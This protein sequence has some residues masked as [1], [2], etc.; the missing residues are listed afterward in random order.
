MGVLKEYNV[1]MIGA[2]PDMIERAENRES[3]RSVAQSIGLDMPK[4]GI[5]NT[6]EE[7]LALAGEMGFPLIIRPSF[8]LGGSGGGIA[9][10]ID[11]FKEIVT[12]GLNTS[13]VRQVLVEESVLGWKE[14]E[15]EL[16][17]DQAGHELAICGIENLDPMGVHTGD[18]ITVAPV[19]TLS[20]PEF[21]ML[22]KE[23]MAIARS[24]GVDSGGC[25]V[26]F[27]ID[28][29]TGR[30]VIIELNPRVS[31]SSALASKA[32]GFPIARISAKLALGYTLNELK[33]GM[34]GATA[35]FEP[36]MDYHIVKVAR[37][38]FAK[39]E[40][41]NATLGFEMMAVGETMASG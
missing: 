16:M 35:C 26:Q 8:T 1:E 40:G 4:S 27:A 29:K 36:S 32:T 18:S 7:A 20:K 14:I 41:A 15:L 28:P 39:F 33:N 12:R 6:G 31:R 11:E 23:G 24:V 5:A 17:R 3:F 34:T 38:D 30:R 10:N 19:Q 22:V 2:R 25:N 13:P 9:F 21:R 37:F